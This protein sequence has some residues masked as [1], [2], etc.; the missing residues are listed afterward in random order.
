VNAV[1]NLDAIIKSNGVPAGTAISNLV[2][3]SSRLEA[4]G[5][6]AD[7]L[8]TTNGPQITLAISNFQASTA[9]LTNLL[10]DLQSG[11]GLAGS[12]LK[13][14][15]LSGNINAVANN[16]AVTTSNL[17]RL[18]FWHWIWYKPETAPVYP[19]AKP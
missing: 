13:S 3:F 1:D 5:N 18:G 8:V 16:L 9:M 2:A 10:S 7:E 6:R 15:Q 4:V 11:K 19:G 17:N 14:E 12:V